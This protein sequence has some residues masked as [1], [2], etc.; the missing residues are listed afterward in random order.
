MDKFS[1]ALA[2]YQAFPEQFQ[3]LILSTVSAEGLP[4]ASYAP[5]VMD[6][7]RNFYIYVSG[8][9]SHTQNLHATAKASL[10]LIQEESQ[11]PQAFA[12]T[13]LSYDCLATL[14]EAEAPEWTA[15]ADQFQAR[16]GPVI[17]MLR[18]LPDFRIFQLKPQAGR[19]VIGFGSIFEVDPQDLSSLIQ[20]TPG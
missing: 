13:R 11:A 1:A 15:L 18:Q 17:D 6:S 3:S 10:L 20:V 4:N 2:T 8:L 12:R 16:F 19:M 9:A 5:F 14:I 7:D